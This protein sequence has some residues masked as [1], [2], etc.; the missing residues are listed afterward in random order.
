LSR[1]AADRDEV[2][3]SVLLQR[4][5]RLV[6]GVCR[7]VLR[8]EHD[9]EDA[10]QATFLVLARRAGAI[11]AE[12]A[13]GSWLYRVAYR[14]A[15]KARKASERR[16]HQEA[17]VATLNE[18][19]PA[20]DIA[21]R[22][23]QAMLDQELNRLPAK[24]RSPFVLCVLLGKSKS[25]AAAE[26]AWKEGTVSSRLSHAR[27][28]LRKRLARRG[29]SL[30]A[31]LSG[32]AISHESGAS[33][34]SPALVVAVQKKAPQFL[35]GDAIGTAPAL[36]AR[37]VLRG[38][39]LSRVALVSVVLF[40]IGLIGASVAVVLHR[41]DD[42]VTPVA[43][44]QPSREDVPAAAPKP[45]EDGLQ[46]MVIRGRVIGTDGK[47]VPG[48]K[49]A[50]LA[51]ETRVAGDRDFSA[52]TRRRV[53][54][55][56]K[57]DEEGKFQFVTPRPVVRLREERI[58]LVRGEGQTVSWQRLH[59][60]TAVPPLEL[61][62]EKGQKLRGQLVDADGEPAAGVTLRFGGF[63]RVPDPISPLSDEMDAPA[64]PSPIV[65][66]REGR[67]EL[68][69]ALRR[70]TVHFRIEDERYG[71]HW[72]ALTAKEGDETDVGK[73][74]LPAPRVLEGTVLAEDTQRPLA[75]AIVVVRSYN[76]GGSVAPARV[77][78]QT[79]KN[80]HF[81][82][83]PYPGQSMSVYV[84]GAPG[85]PYLAAQPTV[86]WPAGATRHKIDLRLQR[87]V[88]LR[89]RV[90]EEGSGRAVPGTRIQYRPING[91]GKNRN[92]DKDNLLVLW[93]WL[94]TASDAN[95]LFELPVLPGPGHLLVRGPDHD[96]I[97][98]EVGDDEL[99]DGKKGGDRLYYPDALVPL[100]LN[101]GAEPKPVVATLRRGVTIKGRVVTAD[102]KPVASGFLISRNYLGSG[103]EQNC[104]YLPVRDGR[105]E[106][107]GCDPGKSEP[108][109]FWDHKA[110]QG[111]MVNLS[112]KDQDTTVR[113]APFGSATL[114]FVDPN[115][116][117]QPNVAARIYLVIR[118][119]RTYRDPP[120][121]L[122]PMRLTQDA[123]F[124]GIDIGPVA[125]EITAKALV[126]GATY[127]LETSLGRGSKPFSVPSGQNVRLPDVVVDPPPKPK[128]Q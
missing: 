9:A 123:S 22:E 26:L 104:E 119:G 108:Y 67:F 61:K 65:T 115:G 112:T 43:V 46:Q 79:D 69:G 116:V 56:G 11:R 66:D 14:V 73:I 83:K 109:W 70:A 58:C 34:V 107:P 76:A 53:I 128:K 54:T 12:Q 94:D 110:L 16:R 47:A 87:G 50:I 68:E 31:L 100:D 111:A 42:A 91:K 57:A 92:G 90:V 35:A 99:I 85:T 106:I 124:Q 30:S 13:I 17:Q 80:G 1:F 21:W 71:P 48:A 27:Q 25:E 24:Y 84:A 86:V 98:M 120:D 40:T 23:L 102:G 39:A 59:S 8:H 64:W 18:Q 2:A 127:V 75:E 74:C 101:A 89:G 28:L 7:N 77:I 33:S 117:V 45:P 113:L 88:L 6:Y 44:D 60:L 32:L 103:W 36:L 4:Y 78:A 10:F 15:V 51:D 38:A 122:T 52:F 121:K 125:G 97:P 20:S 72:L 114:R 41:P 93:Q 105:F 5:G 3:F 49:I 81:T 19:R 82:A 37:S 29:V 96:F 126:P 62:L 118:P 63:H 95:G 55:T